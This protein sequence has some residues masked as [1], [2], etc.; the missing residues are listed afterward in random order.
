MATMEA[1]NETEEADEISG[2]A[3]NGQGPTRS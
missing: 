1:I 3:L 2:T